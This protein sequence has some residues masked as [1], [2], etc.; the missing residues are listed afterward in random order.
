MV[1]KLASYTLPAVTSS[2][3]TVMHGHVRKMRRI[4][5]SY[6]ND[7]QA[8]VEGM[9]LY[10]LIMVVVVVISIGILVGILGGF[11]GQNIG[12][13]TTDPDVIAL[14]DDDGWTLF[15][16]TVRDTDGRPIEGA[17]VYVE[18]E[19][20]A[21]AAK[22]DDDGRATFRVSPDLGAKNVGELAIR[23]KHDGLFG[24]Q[25]RSTN[26]LLVND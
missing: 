12:T 6:K 25:I 18:G 4:G 20:V 19:G 8:S 11:Q 15:N 3:V 2:E 22:T 7:E 24:E 14:D 16:V 17:T 23:V 9:P 21:T 1:L 26:V 5:A 10:M 13:V